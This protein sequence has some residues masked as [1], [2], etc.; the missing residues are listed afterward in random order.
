MLDVR[1]TVMT[2]R[3]LTAAIVVW[4]TTWAAVNPVRKSVHCHKSLKGTKKENVQINYDIEEI[5]FKLFFSLLWP[6]SDQT[7]KP[8]REIL[9]KLN[10]GNNASDVGVTEW[11]R[12]L[13]KY[14]VIRALH[15]RGSTALLSHRRVVWLKN[16]L[17]A[18]MYVFVFSMWTNRQQSV[19]KI[20]HR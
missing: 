5:W 20:C 17:T 19:K 9:G 4:V 2:G 15:V 12:S 1:D 11:Q 18:Y 14:Y 10:K 3:S 8:Q 16:W 6:R 13:F 7:Q